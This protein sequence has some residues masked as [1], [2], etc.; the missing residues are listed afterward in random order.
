[1]DETIIKASIIIHHSEKPN[2]DP[3]VTNYF[4]DIQTDK[5]NNWIVYNPMYRTDDIM[6]SYDHYWMTQQNF[7]LSGKNQSD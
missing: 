1:M 6:L 4:K 3:E 7:L 5:T 2:E